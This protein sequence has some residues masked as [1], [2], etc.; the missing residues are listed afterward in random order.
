MSSL[1]SVCELSVKYAIR[2]LLFNALRMFMSVDF[3]LPA[4]PF[5]MKLLQEEEI[6]HFS[7]IAWIYSIGVLCDGRSVIYSLDCVR[8]L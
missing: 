2:L 4:E 6:L 1:L 5:M 8:K 3:P 7:M